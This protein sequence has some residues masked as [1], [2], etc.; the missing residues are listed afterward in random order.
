MGREPGRQICKPR[1][2]SSILSPGTNHIKDLDAIL[3]LRSARKSRGADPGQIAVSRMN[4]AGE[5]AAKLLTKDEARRTW[6]TCWV[7]AEGLDECSLLTTTAPEIARRSCPR[8][9]KQ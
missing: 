3:V 5:S 7:A 9:G 2:G 4:P 8:S 6:R 1:V